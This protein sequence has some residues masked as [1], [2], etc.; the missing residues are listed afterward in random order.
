[1]SPSR[2]AFKRVRSVVLTK[3]EDRNVLV[4]ATPRALELIKDAIVLVEVTEFP[5]QVV[6]Y[7][8]SLYWLTL[9]VDIPDLERQVI[10]RENISPVVAELDI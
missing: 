8:Y 5:A 6:M 4:I 2:H 3:S 9:H 10:T 1:M 7:R